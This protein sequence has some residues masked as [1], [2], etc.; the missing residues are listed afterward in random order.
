M[1]KTVRQLRAL[2]IDEVSLVDRPANQHGLVAITKRDEGTSMSQLYAADGTP[3]DEDDLQP[4]DFVYDENG[5]EFQALSEDEVNEL[6]AYA[7]DGG[8]P[9][10]DLGP[11]AELAI[12]KAAGGGN[13]RASADGGHAAVAGGQSFITEV[14]RKGGR[15]GSAG[16]GHG[17]RIGKSLGQEL[18]TELSKA[19]SDQDRDQVISKAFELL[20]ETDARALEAIA[21][22]DALEA[23][24]E[25]G[26]YVELAKG[27][28]LPVDD[29]DL[30]QILQ[31]ISKSLT[32]GQLDVV[33]RIFTFAGDAANAQ[34]QEIGSAGYAPSA[35]MGQVNDYAYEVVGKSDLTPEQ[36]TV[37]LFE[38][39][40]EAYDA[41][42]SEM[43][44]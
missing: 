1:T 23:K 27:Y 40:P 33:D 38:A 10:D 9:A 18:L 20:E 2:E 13:R 35:L 4:G 41:Y 29:T 36:A 5:Q 39:N 25:L 16:H 11:L 43:K 8:T 21:K 12:A 44:G 19:A 42:L 22:A 34:S 28:E 37:A 31:T 7:N 32:P 15:R 30:G 3:V 14:K 17:T 6:E 24:A 26:E